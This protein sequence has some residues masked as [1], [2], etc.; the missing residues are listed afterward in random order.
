MHFVHYR[1]IEAREVLRHR[2]VRRT[3]TVPHWCAN[4]IYI[5]VHTV[6]YTYNIR[7]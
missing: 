7:I 3:R 6:L 5:E 1:E 4:A 2:P